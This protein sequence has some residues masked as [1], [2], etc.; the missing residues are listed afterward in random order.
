ML[1][2][3]ITLQRGFMQ[4]RRL[5]AATALP[6]VTPPLCTVCLMGM[7]AAASTILVV[8]ISRLNFEGSSAENDAL[9]R[10][11]KRALKLVKVNILDQYA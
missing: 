11:L 8:A 4:R 10:L 3:T 7:C 9:N 2:E 1:H 6:R 5:V